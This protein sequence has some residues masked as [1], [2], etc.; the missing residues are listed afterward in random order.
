MVT[1]WL[2]DPPSEDLRTFALAVTAIE[3]DGDDPRAQI[4]AFRGYNSVTILVRNGAFTA[5]GTTDDPG[6][7]FRTGV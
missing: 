3:R 5:G 1:R 6:I 7:R 2:Q 4:V